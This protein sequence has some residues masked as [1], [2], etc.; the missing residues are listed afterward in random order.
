MLGLE[1]EVFTLDNSGNVVAGADK[2]IKK[3]KDNDVS[4]DI[5]KECTKLEIY[6]SG[7]TVYKRKIT[8][9]IRKRKPNIYIP[10]VGGASKG[11]I[12]GT[13]TMTAKMLNEFIDIMNPDVIL[14]VHYKAFSHYNESIDEV[15]KLNNNKIHII[16]AGEIYKTDL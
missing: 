14:P 6:I 10:N 7:D 9:A 3:I 4:I 2:L 8:K 13:L 16:K 1:V 11:T 15:L 5:K 12:I